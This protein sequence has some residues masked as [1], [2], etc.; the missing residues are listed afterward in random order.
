MGLKQVIEAG[1]EVSE[2]IIDQGIDDGILKDI[3]VVGVGYKLAAAANDIRSKVFVAK[4]EKFLFE[5]ESQ[6]LESKNRIA[7]KMAVSDQYAERVG[8][9]IAMCIENSNDTRKSELIAKLFLA[10]CFDRLSENEFRRSCDVVTNHFIDDL[11]DFLDLNEAFEAFLNPSSPP[12]CFF[13][14][15]SSPLIEFDG[16]DIETI[17]AGVPGIDEVKE[18]I[19]QYKITQFGHQ[20]RDAIRFTPDIGNV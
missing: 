17:A 16:S 9:T 19:T 10:Y 14:L 1:L 20:F 8:E 4:L 6:S 5:L 18:R 13:F 2:T 12:S 7:T 11:E 15:S 3:P